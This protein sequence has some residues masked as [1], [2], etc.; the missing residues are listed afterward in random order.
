MTIAKPKLDTSYFL[1]TEFARWVA[2]QDPDGSIDNDSWETCA[3]GEFAAYAAHTVAY[4]TR[5]LDQYFGRKTGHSKERA[6]ECG[7]VYD[8]LNFGLYDT[9][10]DLLHELRS[11]V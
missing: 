4:V 11:F 5:C 10:G 6:A 3:V 1:V 8:R 2:M 9:Y 7:T